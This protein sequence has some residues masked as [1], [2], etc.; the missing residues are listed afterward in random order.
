MG[1]F[2]KTEIFFGMDFKVERR[3]R[4]NQAR[5]KQ[6]SGGCPS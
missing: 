3:S 5:G 4:A 1:N 2:V 6:D